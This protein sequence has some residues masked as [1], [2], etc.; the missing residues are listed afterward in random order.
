MTPRSAFIRWPCLLLPFLAGSAWCASPTTETLVFV[1]HGEKPANGENGQLTCQG[2]NRAVSLPLVLIPR[3]GHPNYAFAAAP[4]KNQDDNGVDYWYLRAMATIEPTAVA[5]GITIDLNYD[6]D[7]IDD[8]ETELDKP[9]LA[10]ALVFVAWEHTELDELVVDL[11]RDNGGDSSVVPAWREDDYDSIFVVRITRDSGQT[12][13]TF[14]HDQEGL[15]NASATCLPGESPN[16]FLPS[17]GAGSR[18]E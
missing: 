9:S 6:K 2:Q 1:R 3:Y 14:S 17:N 10:N 8:L 4:V 11:M 18:I 15:D 16:R 5:A 12:T 7:D 13:A